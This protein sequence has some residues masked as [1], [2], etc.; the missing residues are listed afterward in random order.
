MLVLCTLVWGSNTVVGRALYQDV[1]PV[2]LSFWRN[3]VALVVLI[4]FTARQLRAAWPSLRERWG[5]VLACGLVGTALFNYVFY[6]GLHTT[7]AINAGILMALSPA[8]IPALAWIILGDRL[9]GRELLGIGVSSVGVAYLV[10]QGRFGSLDTIVGRVGDFL[11]LASALC[12]SIYSVVVK[13]RPTEVDPL[14]FL[15]AVLFVA[16]LGLM[17]F[18]LWEHFVA[19]PVPLDARSMLAVVYLGVF[20]TAVALW[21]FNLAVDRIGPTRAGLY[22]HLVPVF[23]A[24]LAVIFLGETLE[25]F[26]VLGAIPIA[27]GLYLTTTAGARL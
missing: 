4:P 3:G 17:P 13:L 5:V 11:I 2:G 20:P 18:Y 27:V 6:R 7:T 10:T 14:P 8:I 25:W 9:R 19:R 1:P 24:V 22:I 26:Q 16:V 23:S 12:W 21:L 15:T